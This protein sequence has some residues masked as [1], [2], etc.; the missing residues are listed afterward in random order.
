MSQSTKR[1][2]LFL[3]A[4]VLLSLVLLSS[5]LSNLGLHSGG[6][7]PGGA[8]GSTLPAP[9]AVPAAGTQS[10]PLVH[11]FFAL[12]FLVLLISVPARLIRLADAGKILRWILALAILLLIIVLLPRITPGQP[13]V[14]PAEIAGEAT[15][16]SFEYPTSPLG[17]PPAEF[18]WFV[19]GGLV[20][21]AGLLVIRMLRQPSPPARTGDLLL[22]EAENA[23]HALDA[24]RAFQDVIIRCYM[25]MSRALQE[26]QGLERS[27]DMTV[28]EFEDRLRLKGMP[29]VPVHQLTGLFEK[30]RY[31]KQQP[32]KEDEKMGVDCLNE[33]IQFCRRGSS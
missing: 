22:Q 8:P 30:V 11:G 18:V 21:G 4:S 16:P 19:A 20:L 2:A 25:Q 17:R 24:G 31:G 14:P 12:L 7:F 1:I 5:S 33:I 10:L 26:E 3:L 9:A 6:A 29:P 27:D 15:R 13:A 23:V 32:D 28:R